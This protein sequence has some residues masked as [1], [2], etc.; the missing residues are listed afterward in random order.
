[1]FRQINSARMCMAMRSLTRSVSVGALR[2][3]QKDPKSLVVWPQKEKTDTNKEASALVVLKDEPKKLRLSRRDH[4]RQIYKE[5][6]TNPKVKEQVVYMPMD[7][8]KINRKPLDPARVELV[9]RKWK[10]NQQEIEIRMHKA[11]KKK[12]Y[13]SRF[14]MNAGRKEKIK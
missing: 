13:V 14:E 8:K 9:N 4:L 11:D 7:S 10:E 5:S 12:K 1:M 6:R 3:N 2:W